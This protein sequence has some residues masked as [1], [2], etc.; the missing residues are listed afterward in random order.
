MLLLLVLLL[1]VFSLF[2]PFSSNKSIFPY[3]ALNSCNFWIESEV[4]NFLSIAIKLL[5]YSLHSGDYSFKRI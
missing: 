2:S 3:S 4:N 5:E 1:L